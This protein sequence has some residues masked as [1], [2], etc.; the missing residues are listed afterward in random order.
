MRRNA[1]L[2]RLKKKRDDEQYQ[3]TNRSIQVAKDTAIVTLHTLFGFGPKRL[4]AFSDTFD[5]ELLRWAQAVQEDGKDDDD[6]VYSL[7]KRE[8]RLRDAMGE[9]YEP[10]E[11]RYGSG[12]RK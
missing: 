10:Y 1:Y 4:K 9:F 5:E 6:L 12:G 3:N 2:E 11:V 8:E 7:T